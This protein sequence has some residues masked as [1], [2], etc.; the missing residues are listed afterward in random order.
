MLDHINKPAWL[1]IADFL[2]MENLR[3]VLADRRRAAEGAARGPACGDTQA[4][5]GAPLSALPDGN[6]GENVR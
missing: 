5:G 2:T 1:S 6:H 4:S 3:A